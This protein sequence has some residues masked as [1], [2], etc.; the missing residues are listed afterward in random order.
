MRGW[1][2]P[3]SGGVWNIVYCALWPIYCKNSRHSMKHYYTLLSM[4]SLR[5]VFINLIALKN[6]IFCNNDF[7]TVLTSDCIMSQNRDYS[8]N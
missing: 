5:L 4:T 8:S 6:I 2:P 3:T 1:V 7:N